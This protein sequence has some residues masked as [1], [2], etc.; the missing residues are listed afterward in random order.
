MFITVPLHFKLQLNLYF[1]SLSFFSCYFQLV[2]SFIYLCVCVHS[3]VRMY[4]CVPESL[5]WHRGPI[6]GVDYVSELCSWGREPNHT[7]RRG[8]EGGLTAWSHTNYTRTKHISSLYQYCLSCHHSD[9]RRVFRAPNVYIYKET[10]DTQYIVLN[11][12]TFIWQVHYSWNNLIYQVVDWQ[13]F[14]PQFWE[15]AAFLVL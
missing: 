9:T 13:V 3:G 2:W 12:I 15:F 1:Y 11:D 6:S 10:A 5:Q 7:V 8:G 14:F 4:F